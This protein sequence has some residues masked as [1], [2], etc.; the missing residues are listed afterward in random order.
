MIINGKE[1]KF[2]IMKKSD[3]KRFED[4]LKTMEKHE[5]EIQKKMSA[6]EREGKSE[7]SPI[8]DEFIDMFREFFTTAIGVDV[9]GDCDDAVEVKAM[10]L[11]FLREV[12]KQKKVFLTAGGPSRIK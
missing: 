7:L 4:A 1:I 10:Y 2:S 8:L 9:V 12:T 3:A 6:N 11:T 5:A